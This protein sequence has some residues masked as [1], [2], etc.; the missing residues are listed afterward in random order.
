M[1]T[2]KELQ[3]LLALNCDPDELIQILDISSEDLVERFTDKIEERY[4]ELTEDF[5]EED[6]F[7][8][9]RERYD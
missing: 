4:D 3:Q 5:Q 7:D 2:L 8:E 9:T 6:E 1:L